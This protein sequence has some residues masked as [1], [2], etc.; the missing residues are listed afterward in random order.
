MLGQRLFIILLSSLLLPLMMAKPALS[1]E[2]P[3]N[4]SRRQLIVCVD[5][6]GFSMIAE[7]RSQG[8]FKRFNEPSRMISPFPTLTN[9]SLTEV[10]K[11]VGA[12]EA[13]GYEDNYFDTTS[14]K[15]RG[16]LVDR[17]K[18][19]R[20][21]QGTFRELFDY[22]PSA[23]KS[24]LGYFA[25]PFSSYLE[26][27]IDLKTLKS[28]FR[29]SQGTTF[30]A[31]I[32]STDSIAHLGGR[33]MLRNYLVR[34]ERTLDE[35]VREGNGR[36]DIVVFSDH[37]NHFRSY[38]RV[39][40]K[41]A[42]TKAGL[43][44]EGK[45]RDERSIVFPQFGLIGAAVLFTYP[46]NEARVAE[47]CANVRGVDFAAYGH[48]GTVNVVASTGKARIERRDDH[49][50]YRTT[51]GDPLELTQI[52]QLLRQQGK[53]D[54]EEFASD[55]DWFEATKQSR[56][57]DALRRIYEA[58]TSHV[59]NPANV[60]LNFA[61]GYYTGSYLLDVLAILRAT[62]GNMWQEQSFG[63]AMTT[64][65]K[66][67]PII[68]ARELWGALGSPLLDKRRELARP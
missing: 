42:L 36:V 67:P 64:D 66:L 47:L 62:H 13:L 54:E 11:T 60:I 35:I 4:S 22:H 1:Q 2:Q 8:H 3:M 33:K 41:Q 58:M 29:G 24:G 43:R 23:L 50:R 52:V 16:G 55:E 25:P 38:S 39:S 14:N 59:R 17:F 12:G 68:R 32:G 49:F 19:E 28:K 40:L 15:M 45:L 27:L 56:R 9:V 44:I 18:Q 7:M 34:V 37:G 6:V 65:R 5:G 63:F 48:A 57:P 30:L 51:Q 21:V 46:S 20:F 53:L 61:D 31:Y 26:A 10:L